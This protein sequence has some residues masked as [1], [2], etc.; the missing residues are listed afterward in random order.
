MWK[1]T[2]SHLPV[3]LAICTAAVTDWRPEIFSSQKLKKEKGLSPL[4]LKPN[5]D[6]LAYLA[7]PKM[8]PR[9]LIGFAAETEN[10]LENAKD[11]LS[12]CDWIVAN[13]VREGVFG[14]DDT[15]VHFLTP[16][17]CEAWSPSS[18]KEVAKKLVSYIVGA[19]K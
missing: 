8:R 7:H 4:S 15:K 10:V 2:E 5:P 3:D 11:K 16:H 6:I 12:K 19:L 14:S 13:D 1:A 18:K 9:L 17:V